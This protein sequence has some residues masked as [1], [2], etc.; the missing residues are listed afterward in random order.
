MAP[1]VKKDPNGNP[2]PDGVW[3]SYYPEPDGGTGVA[4]FRS[5]VAALRDAVEGSKLVVRLPYG[6]TLSD[7][8]HRLHEEASKIT[9][10]P[11]QK[12][13]SE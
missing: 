8:L 12:G 1:R 7:Y 6:V 10:I 5:E 11:T 2:E 9:K 13:T 4:V 3:I